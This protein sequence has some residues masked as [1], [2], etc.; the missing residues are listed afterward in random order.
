MAIY[1]ITTLNIW[2]IS[3]SRSIWVLPILKTITIITI[4]LQRTWPSITY[5]LMNYLPFKEKERI[6]ILLP[7]ESTLANGILLSRST[8]Q[9]WAKKPIQG[10]NALLVQLSLNLGMEREKIQ[11]IWW[12]NLMGWFRFEIHQGIHCWKWGIVIMI[13]TMVV[14]MSLW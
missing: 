9:N 5:K 10:K 7:L 4:A 2:K 11:I 14:E 13:V 3:I 6:P 8:N 1:H 12:E